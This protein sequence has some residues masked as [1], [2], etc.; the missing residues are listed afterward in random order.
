MEKIKIDGNEVDVE[1]VIKEIVENQK[2]LAM[3]ITIMDKILSKLME[4]N[5]LIVNE[6]GEVVDKNRVE[7]VG[8]IIL[9]Q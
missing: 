6:K 4:K 3:I 1:S 5:D 2:Q 7:K 9:P 8:S